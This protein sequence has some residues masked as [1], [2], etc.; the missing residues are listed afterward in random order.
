MP[1]NCKVAP[2]ET[3]AIV[4]LPVTLK[5]PVKVFWPPIVWLPKVKTDTPL[6]ALILLSN[7]LPVEARFVMVAY[8]FEAEVVVR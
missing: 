3:F 6:R 2:F 8:V 7:V 4:A 5:L 1:L